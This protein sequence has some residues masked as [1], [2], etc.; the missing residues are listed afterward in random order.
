MDAETY[1]YLMQ[2]FIFIS[3]TPVRRGRI[4]FL[5]HSHPAM[6][7]GISIAQVLY[8][9]ELTEWYDG[10]IHEWGAVGVAAA[11]EPNRIFVLGRDGQTAAG[12]GEEMVESNLTAAKNGTAPMRGI[13][14]IGGTLIAYGMNRQVYRLGTDSRWGEFAKGLP[15]QSA[16]PAT[17]EERIKRAIDDMSGFNA[18][19]GLSPAELYAVGTDGE[20][21]RTEKDA[22]KQVDSPTNLMLTDATVA[23]DGEI[24]ACG[25]SGI[26]LRGRHDMWDVVN[27]EGPQGL[28]FRAVAWFKDFLYIADG[29][30]VRRIVDGELTVV[31][32]GVDG[33]VPAHFL[34][35]DGDFLLTLAGK[36]IYITFDGI[37]WTPVLN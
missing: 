12:L 13:R 33:I 8:L 35:A 7:E 19:S 3:A 15:V 4:A 32:F 29:H 21:W 34:Y 16:E 6:R 5:A 17:S 31:D 22:W 24:F 23:P 9:D 25:L 18:V 28:D 14:N 2:G 37:T 20:I 27:Y 10:S 26:L 30:S 36:E 11:A 1:E